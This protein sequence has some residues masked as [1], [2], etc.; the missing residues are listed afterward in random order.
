M[1]KEMKV[2]KEIKKEKQPSLDIFG[3][4]PITQHIKMEEIDTHPLME[5]KDEEEN[6]DIPIKAE[7]CE[8]SIIKSEPSSPEFSHLPSCSTL[9]TP[10]RVDSLQDTVPQSQPVSLAVAEEPIA[11]G[12]TVPVN[13]D[14]Q[15][16]SD[17][18]DDFNVDVMLDN[19]VY[20]KSEC[21]EGSAVSVKQEKEVKEGMTEGG[22]VSNVLG[23][24]SK[25]QVKRVTWNIQEP[26]GPQPE[27]SASSKCCC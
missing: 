14:V 5:V 3:D 19:L 21:T 11:D 16:P 10:E 20:E 23:T 7:T 17:S 6:T 4:S 25:N 9:S 24:K 8:F 12:L 27:K 26:E 22:Q 1:A 15:Q 2:E 18:D 13:Q